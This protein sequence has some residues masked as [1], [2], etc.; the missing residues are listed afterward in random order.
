MNKHLFAPLS[1]T[2]VALMMGAG[3]AQAQL[4]APTKSEGKDSLGSGLGAPAPAAPAAPLPTPSMPGGPAGEKPQTGEDVVQ[5]IANCVLVGL[6]PDWALAQIEVKEI[7]R[8]DKQR[9]FEAFFTYQDAAG[10]ASTFSPCDARETALNVYK[11]NAALEPAKRNWIR[12]TLVLSKEGKFELQYDYAK[13]D[14]KPAADAKPAA[15]DAKK[16]AKKDTKKK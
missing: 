12:A 3:A 6:P 11:L 9:E 16:A 7:S 1:A 13:A 10:K 2:L 5:T 4:K 15:A 14:E 8:V